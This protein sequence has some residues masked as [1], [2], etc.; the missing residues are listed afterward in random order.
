[1]YRKKISKEKQLHLQADGRQVIVEYVLEILA[2]SP[3][4]MYSV[5][6]SEYP[7]PNH[8][9]SLYKASIQQETDTK[10]PTSIQHALRISGKTLYSFITFSTHGHLKK[11]KSL[12]PRNFFVEVQRKLCDFIQFHHN[13]L[14]FQCIAILKQP[15]AWI[16]G[17]FLVEVQR[18]PCD[19]LRSFGPT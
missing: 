15:K 16:Q 9:S 19:R 1:M 6:C 4:P 10:D 8:N 18:K 12:D 14:Y 2:L 3:H 17:I 11:T 7:P 5:L 13:F